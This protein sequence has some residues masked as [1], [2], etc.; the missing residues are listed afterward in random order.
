REGLCQLLAPEA[1]IAVVGEAGDAQEARQLAARLR[2]DVVLMDINLPGGDG[3]GAA[4]AILAERPQTAVVMLTM[5]GEVAPGARAVL[6]LLVA[7]RSNKEIARELRLAVSTVKND[8]SALF[9]KLGARDRTQAAVR[10]L[11]L[12]LAPEGGAA[13]AA[14]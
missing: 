5:Y 7:G 11:A 6:G 2:P 1:D 4:E 8:L 10:A 13:G 14:R 9:R 12:G 3:V